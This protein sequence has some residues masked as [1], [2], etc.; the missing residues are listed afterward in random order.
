VIEPFEM[1]LIVNLRH[2]VERQIESVLE[3]A[4]REQSHRQA[5]REIELKR[6]RNRVDYVRYLRI[7]DAEEAREKPAA[8]ADIL[9]PDVD[10]S[11]PGR[12]RSHQYD[13]H[14]SAA[15]RLRES[16]YRALATLSS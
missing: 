5:T 16:G 13:N 9:F 15:H 14:R 10:N 8:I 3:I 7:L 4:K 1:A 12:P 6:P 2:P 11:Y